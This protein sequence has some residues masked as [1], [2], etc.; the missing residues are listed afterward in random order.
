[1]TS[2]C[3]PVVRL[4]NGGCRQPVLVPVGGGGEVLGTWID[5]HRNQFLG[6]MTDLQMWD[7]VPLDY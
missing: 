3:L 4:W 1:M 7:T 6:Q 2:R 5:G